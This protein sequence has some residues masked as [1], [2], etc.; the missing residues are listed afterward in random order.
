MK[1]LFATTG[2]LALLA[3]S[4]LADT[5]TVTLNATVGDYLAIT[6]TSDSTI[7]D[8]NIAEGSGNPANSNVTNASTSEKALFEVT[9]N[10]DYT[11]ELDWETWQEATLTIPDGVSPTYQ[12]ANYLNSAEGCSIGGTVSFD[13][14][15][16]PG[17]QNDR[18][19]ATGGATP[20]EV[21]GT[22]SPGIDTYGVNTEASPNVTNCDNGVAAQGTYSIGVAITVAA[23]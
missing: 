15:P 6:D 8:L 18:V 4:A 12:Q 9:S 21:P 3:T 5:A 13:P 17:S 16:D 7:G 20:L 10:V 2:A 14:D 11:I 23:S 1:A 19:I 22:F